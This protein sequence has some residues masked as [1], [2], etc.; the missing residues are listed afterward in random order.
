LLSSG[1]KLSGTTNCH[2]LLGSNDSHIPN[3]NGALN[4]A[5]PLCESP[6]R[7]LLANCI[8]TD[9]DV[10]AADLRHV[11]A[12]ENDLRCLHRTTSFVGESGDVRPPHT[13][14]SSTVARCQTRGRCKESNPATVEQSIIVVIAVRLDVLGEPP[15]TPAHLSIPIVE[16]RGLTP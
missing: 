4:V 1:A 10:L 8:D 2:L 12:L 16:Q 3:P 15:R 13:L 11:L 14:P 6:L 9:D 5:V 7:V